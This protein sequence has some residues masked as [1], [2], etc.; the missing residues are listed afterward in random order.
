MML[1]HIKQNLQTHAGPTSDLS[2]TDKLL[3]QRELE[4]RGREQMGEADEM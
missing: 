3:K 4:E 1:K 2:W